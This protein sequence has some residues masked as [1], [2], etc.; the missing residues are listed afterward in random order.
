MGRTA[1]ALTVACSPRRHKNC[2]LRDAQRPTGRG[3]MAAISASSSCVGLVK[4]M[5]LNAVELARSSR[6]CGEPARRAPA[7]RTW[8]G[9]RSDVHRDARDGHGSRWAGVYAERPP[10]RQL[11]DYASTARLGRATARAELRRGAMAPSIGVAG[12][13]AAPRRVGC[14]SCPIMVRLCVP[15]R[16]SGAANR[17]VLSRVLDAAGV[18]REPGGRAAHIASGIKA[19]RVTAAKDLQRFVN[20][21]DEVRSTRPGAPR[22]T[23]ARGSRGSAGPNALSISSTRRSTHHRDIDARRPGSSTRS[24]DAGDRLRAERAERGPLRL[25]WQSLRLRRS[26]PLRARRPRVVS[27]GI[28]DR[29]RCARG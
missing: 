15:S 5:T 8:L 7:G 2:Q 14:T 17:A 26:R 16:Q 9:T 21:M 12:S 11:L 23:N 20:Y 18:R 25:P 4:C 19:R 22:E 1:G 6:A 10:L 3:V 24:P 13:G 27:E 29:W 28:R